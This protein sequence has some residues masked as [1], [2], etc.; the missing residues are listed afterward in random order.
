MEPS[1]VQLLGQPAPASQPVASA[2]LQFLLCTTS[3]PMLEHHIHTLWLVLLFPLNN[4]LSSTE[5]PHPQLTCS[6][7]SL[8]NSLL[9]V[10]VHVMKQG[11]ICTLPKMFF[12]LEM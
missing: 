6:E 5:A 4:F 1:S 11:I 2:C 7:D 8:R 9:R 3:C 12:M 10:S